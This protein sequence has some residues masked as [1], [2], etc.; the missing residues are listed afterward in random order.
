LTEIYLIDMT[1]R[2]LDIKKTPIDSIILISMQNDGYRDVIVFDPRGN[3]LMH[4]DR[5]A[6]DTDRVA[7]GA[8]TRFTIFPVAESTQ[9][10]NVF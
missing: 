7:P 6:T 5:R 10:H 8:A 9:V 4:A 2:Y 1:P 3:R